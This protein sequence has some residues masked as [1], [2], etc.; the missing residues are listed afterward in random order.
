MSGSRSRVATVTLVL[1]AVVAAFGCTRSE[2]HAG[3]REGVSSVSLPLVSMSASGD[4]YVLENVRVDIR[5]GMTLVTSLVGNDM[6]PM[7]TFLSADLAA[8]AYTAEL[9]AGW[10]LMQVQPDD[11]R[12]EVAA[13]L[14]GSPVQ[15]FTVQNEETDGGPVGFGGS[16]QIGFV[17]EN[18]VAGPVLP[19]YDGPCPVLATGTVSVLRQNVQLWVGAEQPEPG[20]VVFYWHGTASSSGEAQF[21]MGGAFDDIL[22]RGGMIASFTTSTGTGA[23][24]SGTG[25]WSEGD[26][27]MADILLAC[28]A[29]Q[30]NIDTRRIYTAGCSSGGLQAGAMTYD[31]SSYLA[32]AM[33]NSGGLVLSRMPQDSNVPSV[34]T[35][36]GGASD[37]VIIS[38][39]EASATL[40]NGIAAR[41]GYA[42]NCDHGGGHCGG[43]PE[44]KLAQWQYLLDH[45]FGV[46]PDPYPMGLPASFPSFCTTIAP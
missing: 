40:Y 41:G 35:A 9:V 10:R 24:T 39:A 28:A 26:F 32:G 20:P 44:L 37:V 21:M 43:P 4:T 11:S 14:R 18:E 29:Q 31:R 36:H 16:V 1:A 45:P 13:T 8:G 19:D 12:V 42:A 2:G 5:Q 23:N 17:V 46:S 30:L 7:E 33:P 38:F 6:D 3:S 25:T 27:E 15:S 22:S 34:I